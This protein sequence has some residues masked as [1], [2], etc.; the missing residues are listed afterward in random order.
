[1]IVVAIVTDLIL[2]SR[3]EEAARR[4]GAEYIRVDDPGALPSPDGVE[5]LLV[6]WSARRPGWAE[7]MRAWSAVA[8]GAP[9]R[10]IL[11]GP[12]TDLDAHA[13]A[14]AEGLG[15][16]WARSKLVAELPVLLAL[17]APARE[18]ARH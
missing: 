8:P 1:M 18:W 4:A 9:P 2:A 16:M 6:D 3:I 12:H 14:R 10:L 5:L 11:F 15:P 13:A 7:T 17:R